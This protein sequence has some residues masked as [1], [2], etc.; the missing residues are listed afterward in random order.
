MPE[1]SECHLYVNSSLLD[2]LNGA[3]Q[4]PIREINMEDGARLGFCSQCLLVPYSPAN[5]VQIQEELRQIEWPSI[6]ALTVLADNSQANL[7]TQG[8]E[9]GIFQS[10]FNRRNKMQRDL[11]YSK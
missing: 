3:E 6:L 10:Q 5:D 8:K 11:G 2:G 9:I 1:S 7:S 4:Q